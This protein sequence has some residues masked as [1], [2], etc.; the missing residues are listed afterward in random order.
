MKILN[1][2]PFSAREFKETQNNLFSCS[3]LNSSLSLGRFDN[4]FAALLAKPEP[5]FSV[6]NPTSALYLCL[7]SFAETPTSFDFLAGGC[8][9]SNVTKLLMPFS[10]DLFI[11]LSFLSYFSGYLLFLFSF[12]STVLWTIS[13]CSNCKKGH[14]S[15]CRFDFNYAAEQSWAGREFTRIQGFARFLPNTWIL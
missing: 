14:F 3:L 11:L 9:D 8:S 6:L 12:F 15:F 1:C 2:L 10:F 7:I 4:F 13:S 5:G